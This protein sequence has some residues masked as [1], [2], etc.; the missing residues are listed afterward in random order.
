MPGH[1]LLTLDGEIDLAGS[2]ELEAVIAR[3][4]PAKHS[5]IVVDLAAVTFVNTP[6]W[7]VFLYYQHEAE[8]FG[9]RIVICG[10][11]GRPKDSFDIAGIEGLLEVVADKSEAV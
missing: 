11:Q 3:L 4:L 6:G 9:G 2:Q 10:L 7:A 5:V 1:C 8:S